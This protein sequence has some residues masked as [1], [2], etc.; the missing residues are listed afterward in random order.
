MLKRLGV[1]HR[2]GLLRNIA[3]PGTRR[4]SQIP[5]SGA[6]EERS[7]TL[8]REKLLQGFSGH[9]DVALA[10]RTRS[11]HSAGRTDYSFGQDVE[12]AGSL[13]SADQVIWKIEKRKTLPVIMKR[14]D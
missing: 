9:C 5:R 7:G 4:A 14:E 13:R 2:H 8:V 10:A 6:A 1:F 12:R 11:D 3:R